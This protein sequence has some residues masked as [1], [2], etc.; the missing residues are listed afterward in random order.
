VR[1]NLIAQGVSYQ[2]RKGALGRTRK[3]SVDVFSVGNIPA[4]KEESVDINNGK[5]YYGSALEV[6]KKPQRHHATYGFDAVDLVAVKS[7][8]EQYRWAR[9]IAAKD[10]HRHVNQ[11]S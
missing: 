2:A 11:G 6:V 4:K 7:A 1:E 10:M 5:G 9:A 3:T 8:A